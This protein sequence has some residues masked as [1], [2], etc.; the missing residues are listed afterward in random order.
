MRS[1]HVCFFR[2]VN[3]VHCMHSVYTDSDYTKWILFLRFHSSDSHFLSFTFNLSVA[4][5]SCT[6]DSSAESTFVHSWRIIGDARV[7]GKKPFIFLF[8]KTIHTVWF[9]ENTLHD[10]C[11]SV[12]VCVFTLHSHA[13]PSLQ[14]KLDAIEQFEC[15]RNGIGIQ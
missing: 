7:W 10:R 2:S 1:P 6:V 11:F 4:H 14:M 13:L 8:S 9:A 15:M 3:A 12:C 5:C